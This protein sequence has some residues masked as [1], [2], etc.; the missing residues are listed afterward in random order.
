MPNRRF[1][2]FA[3]FIASLALSSPVSALN[4]RLTPAPLRTGDLAAMVFSTVGDSCIIPP[5]AGV[6]IKREASTLVGEFELADFCESTAVPR[7]TALALGRIESGIQHVEIRAC[8]NAPP[9]IPRCSPIAQASVLAGGSAGVAPV[10][11]PHGSAFTTLLL[12]AA[13]LHY[14]RRW[15]AMA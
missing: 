9:G 1:A 5:P 13:I 15:S 6:S 11:V 8:V 14:T 2:A 7:E 12:I 3:L 4:I 10:T